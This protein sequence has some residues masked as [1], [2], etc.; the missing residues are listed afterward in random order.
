MA[1]VWFACSLLTWMLLRWTSMPH[2][3]VT[4]SI[5]RAFSLPAARRA[6]NSWWAVTLV[7]AL[8]MAS[9]ALAC[10]IRSAMMTLRGTSSMPQSAAA[11][12]RC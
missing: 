6:R 7:V 9:K 11:V 2:A 5:V 12:V 10:S 3:A 1:T 4:L 8:L